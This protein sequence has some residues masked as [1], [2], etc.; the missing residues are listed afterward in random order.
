MLAALALALAIALGLGL[1]AYALTSPEIMP[2]LASRRQTRGGAA[3]PSAEFIFFSIFS[4]CYLMW[5]T[6]PISIGSSRHFEPGRLL[7][8]PISLRKLFA[9]DFI[10]ELASLQSV[11]ALP[12]IIAIGVGAGLGNGM[13]GW[14]L[15]AMLPA[16][17]FGLALSKWLSI[18]VGAL[19]RRKRTRGETLL[20]LIGVGVG[21]GGALIGQ[22]APAIFKHAESFKGLRWTPSG[23]AAFALTHGM[24]EGATAEYLLALATLS[25]FTLILI[26]AGYWIARRAALGTGG[27]KRNALAKQWLK[28][29]SYSG[30]DFPWLSPELGA[31]VEKEL[32][33]VLRNA[34]LRMMVLMPLILVVVRLMNSSRFGGS[35]EGRPGGSSFASELLVYTE[36]LMA[37]GGVLYVFLIL[38]GLS[39]NQFAFEEGGMRSLILSPVARRKI[40]MGKNIALT[41][42]ALI[43]STA[44]LIIN[45]LVFHDLTPRAILFVAL[46]FIT[47]AA[48]MCVIG[49]WLSISFPKRMKFGKRLN[50]S[51]VVGLLLIPMLILLS[52][53][54][55]AATAAGYLTQS[56]YVEYA[57]LTLFAGLAVFA[58][59]LLI[60]EQG[61]ALQ[62]RE[63]EILE[64]VREPTDD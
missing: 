52:L 58:Y 7:L 36:G 13:V 3:I 62:R 6:L 60:D 39:C 59:L 38:T 50:V 20:A 2:E 26:L 48:L 14:A 35:G 18:S 55:L 28:T 24:R 15:L 64:A 5:A 22:L 56:W 42:V 43:F 11:F 27:A 32:R 21:L 1:V 4:F 61:Q 46:N 63:V 29:E 19:I 9:F 31:V 40:L 54:P 51:G 8:Y 41:L 30:W 34:Q 23:A 17:A 25:G 33:Y 49:N 57:T 16:A 47:F 53:P 37:T 44:L 12:A 10:S 45:E